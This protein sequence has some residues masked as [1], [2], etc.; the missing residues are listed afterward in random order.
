MYVFQSFDCHT[1]PAFVTGFRNAV[2]LLT[3][4][5]AIGTVVING[6]GRTLHYDQDRRAQML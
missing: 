1:T 5:I 3:L 4:P 6:T 2:S